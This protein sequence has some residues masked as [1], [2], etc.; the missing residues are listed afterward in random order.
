MRTHHL[1]VRLATAALAA[2]FTGSTA[3]AGEPTAAISSSAKPEGSAFDKLWGLA[4]LYKSDGNPIVQELKFTGRLQADFYNV[5]ADQ[6]DDSDFVNR[7]AGFGFKA[8]L[9]GDFTAHAEMDA[10]I[11]RGNSFYNKLTDA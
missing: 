7:R 4:T 6:G 8:K 5:D 3:I 9:F 11:E 2:A 10:N 1:P